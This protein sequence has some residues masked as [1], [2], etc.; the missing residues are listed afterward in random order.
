MKTISNKRIFRA[1]LSVLICLTLVFSCA[2]TGL[3]EK[4]KEK[5]SLVRVGYYENEVFEEGAHENTVKK[6]YAYEYYRKLSEYTGWQYEYVYGSYADLYQALLNGDIDLLAGLAYKEEREGLIAYPD[7]IMGSEAFVLVK[8]ESDN[9]INASPSSLNNMTIGVLKS[10]IADTLRDYLDHNNVE[11]TVQTFDGNEELFDAFETQKIDVLAAEGDGAYGR[12][13]AEVICEFGSSGYYLCV[14]INRPD[15][16]EELNTAQSQLAIEEPNYLSDLKREFYSVSVSGRAFTE[17]EKKWLEEH[18]SL[19]VGYLEDYLPYSDTDKDGNATGLVCEY[20]PELFNSMGISDMEV[21]YIGY[22]SSQAMLQAISDGSIDVA[23]PVGGGLYYS[24]EN[25]IYQSTSIVSPSNELVYKKDFGNETPASFSV[26]KNNLMQYYYVTTN[27][28]DAEIVMYDSPYACLD[29]VLSGEVDCST[30]DGLRANDILKNTKYSSLSLRQLKTNETRCFGV[31]IGNEE[32]LKLINRGINI[33][34]TDYALTIAYRYT[35]GL[36][37]YTLLDTIRNH[38]LAFSLFILLVV[39]IIIFLLLL[40]SHRKKKQMEITESAKRELEK[41]NAELADSQ[42]ALSDALASAEYANRAKTVFLNNMSHDIRTPMNAIVGFTTLAENNVDNKE[43]VLDYLD[44]I[45]ISSRHLLSLIDDVLDMSRI[46]SGKMKIEENEVNLPDLIHD[47]QTIIQSNVNA[48]KLTLHVDVK[49][50]RNE[51]IITDKLRLNQLLLNIL[52][53]A[54]KFTPQGGTISF[55][56]IEKPQLSEEETM[57]EFRIKDTGIGMSE[58]F[59]EAIFDAFTRERS[60]TVS[61][62]QG[63][64]LGMAIAKKIV[65][66][67][68]GTISVT[69]QVGEGTEFVVN[70]PCRISSNAHEDQSLPDR[71]DTPALAASDDTKKPSSFH[72][73]GK[74]ILLAEDNELNRIIAV[75]VLEEEGLAV[76]VAEDGAIA[77]DKIKNADAGYYDLIMM[78][79]QMPNMDGYEAAKQIRALN[80]PQKANIPIIAVTANAFEEDR[81]IALEAGMNSHLAKPYDIPVMMETLASFLH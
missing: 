35:S 40:Y 49:D 36:Y 44:N 3:A 2:T 76:D 57:F 16:L 71:S 60:S 63:T 26:N 54:I 58:E 10:A 29:A 11:A 74:R 24:E 7:E 15:L 70:I 68:G 53:N 17:G 80:D 78:D 61:G 32:L 65:D 50:I 59:Q 66:L 30:L 52:S 46:E 47:L 43:K 8:H 34:G 45:S 4:E 31:K 23:F 22:E 33:L 28:P 39:G 41:K 37:N 69:S 9:R 55:C 77:L 18:N 72:F 21:T 20:V 81:K 14:N 6:G 42:A 56:V 48:K 79:I 1:V 38:M 75:S 12:N 13:D 62:I 19:T 51:D 5:P 27:F 25:G 67:M 64:G 73:E